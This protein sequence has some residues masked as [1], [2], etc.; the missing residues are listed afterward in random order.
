M[1]I[2]NLSEMSNTKSKEEEMEPVKKRHKVNVFTPWK[3]FYCQRTNTPRKL[4][5][6]GSAACSA[7]YQ[8][9]NKQR[10]KA[11]ESLL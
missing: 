2:P 8:K 6:N 1:V 7:C 3:C 5:Y 10:K 11:L 4:K 9:K